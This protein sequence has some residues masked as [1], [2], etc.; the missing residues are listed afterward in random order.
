M[1]HFAKLEGDTV[2]EVVV[3]HNS[4]LTING[5]EFE[6]LGEEFC[7]KLFGGKWIQTSYNKNFRKNFA[8]PGY[9]FDQVRNAFIPPKPFNS[10]V[11]NEETCLWE[12]PIEYPK[13]GPYSWNEENQSWDI[14]NPSPIAYDEANLLMSNVNGDET[15]RP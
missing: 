8:F 9:T 12:P 11:L 3:I 15:K 6:R 13:N 7:A 10:W 4:V 14:G 1:A 2:V 5:V